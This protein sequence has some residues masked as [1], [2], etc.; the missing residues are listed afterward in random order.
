MRNMKTIC[1]K[2][3]CLLLVLLVG[4]IAKAESITSPNGQLQL[5][6]S[7]NAQGEPVYE[8][9]YKGKPVINPSKLG[10]ELKNDPGLMNGFTLADAKTSTFDETWE[11]VWGEVKQIRNHYN[12]LAV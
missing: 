3:A 11:P 12:E 6:F 7:V 4:G 8:L 5:N 1:T 2:L 9:S 10:L